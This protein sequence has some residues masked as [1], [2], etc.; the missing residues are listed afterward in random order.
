MNGSHLPPPRPM[1]RPPEP[2]RRE[3][4]VRIKTWHDWVVYTAFALLVIAGIAFGILREI[5]IWTH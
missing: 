4:Y 1:T 2:E 3:M 5:R